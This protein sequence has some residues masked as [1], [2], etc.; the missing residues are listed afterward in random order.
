VIEVQKFE[1]LGVTPS[2]G[3]RGNA[4]P[5]T[6]A[7]QCFDPTAAIQQ[8]EVSGLAVNVQNVVVADSQTVQ[9]VFEIGGL[10]PLGFR[11]VK[12]QTGLMQHT[13]SNAFTVTP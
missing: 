6:I 10:A 7:G 1:V 2:T 12:V 3:A 4:V 8:V 9:C 5:V 13:R 11:D